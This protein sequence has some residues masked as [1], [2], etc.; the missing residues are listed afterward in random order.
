M[1]EKG[2]VFADLEFKFMY[3]AGQEPLVCKI[4]H[5]PDVICT[6]IGTELSQIRV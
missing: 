6:E 3:T 2:N 5:I 4:L 1:S